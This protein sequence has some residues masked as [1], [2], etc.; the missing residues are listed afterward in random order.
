MQTLGDSPGTDS[1]SYYPYYDLKSDYGWS[2]LFNLID[3][4]IIY[5]IALKIF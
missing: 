1:S 2:E 5:P 3:T 4:L